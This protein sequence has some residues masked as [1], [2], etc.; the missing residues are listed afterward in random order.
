MKAEKK[1]F[2]RTLCLDAE[3]LRKGWWGALGMWVWWIRA[4]RFTSL[5][6][7]SVW[8]SQWPLTNENFLLARLSPPFLYNAAL[9]CSVTFRHHTG[10]SSNSQKPA[11]RVLSGDLDNA[12]VREKSLAGPTMFYSFKCAS[13]I[14]ITGSVLSNIIIILIPELSG[15]AGHIVK[16]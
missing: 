8:H 14:G 5:P 9:V 13:L 2:L 3:F 7:H 11:N 4:V 6:P 12:I 1:E 16:V 10:G 15:G